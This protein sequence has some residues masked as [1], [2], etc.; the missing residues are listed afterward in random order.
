[1][2]LVHFSNTVGG[3]SLRCEVI[4]KGSK[5]SLLRKC[6]LTCACDFDFAA[7]TLVLTHPSLSKDLMENL[8]TLTRHLSV[9]RPFSS[10][11]T[12]WYTKGRLGHDSVLLVE[13]KMTH[14]G[15]FSDSLLN[16]SKWKRPA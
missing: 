2:V 1:M 14:S 12:V 11:C 10:F 3:L 7:K 4:S 15:R 9:F 5:I 8:D 16:R 6:L 13:L